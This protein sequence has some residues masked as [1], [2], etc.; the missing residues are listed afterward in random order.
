LISGYLGSERRKEKDLT[1]VEKR[2]QL[3]QLNAAARR[4]KLIELLQKLKAF[5]LDRQLLTV[6]YLVLAQTKFDGKTL[7]LMRILTRGRPPCFT[8]LKATLVGFE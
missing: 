8:A 4:L 3:E 7:L 6:I 1:K 5:N 2:R